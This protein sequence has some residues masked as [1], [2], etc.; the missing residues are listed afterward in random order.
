MNHACPRPPLGAAL[1][2]ALVATACGAADDARDPPVDA[3][4]A[5]DATPAAT[6]P[7][8][9]PEPEPTTGPALVPR[10]RVVEAR[11]GAWTLGPETRL[12]AAADALPMARAL[13]EKLGAVAGRPIPV[14]EAGAGRGDVVL[15][16][17]PEALDAEGYRLEVGAAGVRLTGGDAAGLFY[18]SQTLLQLLP[19]GAA[20]VSG[21]HVED[22]PRFAWRGLMLDVA[23]HFFTVAEV[24]RQIDLMAMHKLNRL[25][26]HLTDDQGWRL[27]IESW[28]DLTAISG[29]TEVGGGMAGFY[30]RDEYR[31][32]VEYAAERHIVVVPEIDFPGH[33]NAALAAYASLNES[34]ERAAPHFG[35]GVI[36]TPLWLAG[37][38]TWRMVTDVWTEV[39][40]LTPGPWLHLGGDEAVGT[41]EPE[42]IAFMQSLDEHIRSL[43]KTSLGWDE[44]AIAAL[45]PPFAVQ[46][47]LEAGRA[48][49]V[50]GR[51][52]QVIM[53]PA[54]HCYLDMRHDA[55]AD[56]GQIWAGFV[57][58]EK[59][60]DWDPVLPGLAEAD[61]LGV[62]AAVWT[63]FIEDEAQ[64]DFMTWPR[65]AALAEVGWTPQ[66]DRDWRDFRT[67]L[68]AH[69][70]RLDAL[71]VG[72]YASP[73]I[74][75]GGR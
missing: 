63:E 27:E 56:F 73:E 60:Y 54:G 55:D 69:G 35:A 24:E 29:L 3:A 47:W 18:A 23:R 15:T 40:A 30:T 6:G 2:A 71:G 65:L 36:S 33:A 20:R 61:V 8:A 26:L 46:Y 28:P 75:F 5:T 43:G 38:E 1:V 44:A 58:V 31:T 74:D 72:Y 4:G 22:A 16:L 49:D 14:V 59:A 25:H 11:P 64:L 57:D 17:E 21:V 12:V 52:G 9:A 50:V 70:A 34:G 32:L 37:P 7:D 51:G 67:R 45:P 62:E 66:E 13:A 19:P 48:R 53:S 39:A 68:A 10:P 42:Y 41:P